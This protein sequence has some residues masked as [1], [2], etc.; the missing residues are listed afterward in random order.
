M[1]YKDKTM[2]SLRQKGRRKG[3]APATSK[4]LSEAPVEMVPPAYIDGVQT[5]PARPRFHTCTDGQVLDRLAMPRCIKL[6]SA[7]ANANRANAHVINQVCA[8]RYRD[9]GAGGSRLLHLNDGST[10]DPAGLIACR[11]SLVKLI[12]YLTSVD[13]FKKYM[14][15]IRFG[16]RGPTLATV[17]QVLE[18]MA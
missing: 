6:D 8:D 15:D 17:A 16:A 18:A 13:K 14:T 9:R 7:L 11:D 2:K 1:P 3:E 10:L 12:N 4:P 5:L